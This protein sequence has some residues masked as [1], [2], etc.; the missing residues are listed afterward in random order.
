MN[1]ATSLEA[2]L[3]K[4]RV[5]VFAGLAALTLAAWAYLLY[6]WYA[7]NYLNMSCAM[8][9]GM[10]MTMPQTQAWLP[11]DL[12]M[13]FVMWAVMMVAMMIPSAAPMLL[14]FAAVNRKRREQQHPFVPTSIFL[15]GY[16]TVWTA[17]SLIATGAQFTLH[18]ASLLSPAMVGTSP[19][20]GGALLVAAGL[21]QWTRLKNA[22]LSQCQ[23]P[24]TFIMTGWREGKGGA[25]RMGLAHGIYCVGCCWILMG[26]LF[27]LGVMNLLWIAALAGFVLLE[28]TIPAK[29]GERVSRAAGLLFIAWG[30]GMIFNA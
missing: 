24:L 25:F 19:I 22:C 6:D 15:L 23:N 3:K 29:Y 30:L 11:M 14:T 17:Y 21:F 8:H 9:M 4:D 16:I 7:M 26:L 18:N 27:V 12:F 28:K 2:L 1:E 13:L 5:L 20:L 10:E